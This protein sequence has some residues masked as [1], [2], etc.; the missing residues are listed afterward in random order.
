MTK[1]ISRISKPGIRGAGK[2]TSLSP[3]AYGYDAATPSANRGYIYW[4]SL[5]PRQEIN[6]WSRYEVARK[7]HYLCANIG[8]PRRI[9]TCM[10][11][12]VIGSGHTPQATTS[13]SEWNHLAE[14]AYKDRS[15]SA[16]SYDVAG[17]LT[18]PLMQRLAYYTKKKDGDAAIVFS[19]SQSG[20]ALR[21]LYSGIQIGNPR[22][23]SLDDTITDG[24][25]LDS[26]GRPLTFHILADDYQI[27]VPVSAS[28]VVWLSSIESPGQLRGIS[29]LAHAVNKVMDI[30][31]LN[32]AV[33]QGIK[34][35]N[36]IGYYLSTTDKDATGGMLAALAGGN[37]ITRDMGTDPAGNPM[38]VQTAQ[39]FGS[40][41]EIKEMPAGYDIK[42]VQDSRLH[43]NS[44]EFI[45]TSLIRDLSWG[46]GLSADLL[47]SID[48]I[49]GAPMRYVLADARAW[50]E[51]EQQEFVDTFLARDWVYTIAKEMKAGRLRKCTDPRWW[52][53]AWVPPASITVDFGRDGKIYLEQ[54][55]T[56]L[57]STER[58]YGMAGQDAKE[59]ISKEMDLA[60]W[61]KGELTRR[62]LELTDLYPEIRQIQPVVSPDPEPSE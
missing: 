15:R 20:G 39:I 56:G 19:S 29:C 59:E 58:I 41:G 47:W 9:L 37:S 8:L 46:C 38:K 60:E 23:G 57:L 10:T 11:N 16:N 44:K 25:Q 30:A 6:A 12:M 4:P 36:Q 32:T 24:I 48:R 3:S 51:T 14:R 61:R 50:V 49:G 17:T 54:H 52:Q 33:M 31:E 53:H 42:T 5:N 62:G 28:N 35:S 21:R 7:V 26:L 18:G 40:G 2:K 27:S 1:K 43:P 34:L 45:E 55:R 13:D 22:D